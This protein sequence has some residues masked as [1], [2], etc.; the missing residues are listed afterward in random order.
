MTYRP[1]DVAP[2]DIDTLIINRGLVNIGNSIVPP[3]ANVTYAANGAG[4]LTGSYFYLVTYVTAAGETSPWVGQATPVALTAQQMRVTL[5]AAPAGVTARRLYR[6]IAG[7]S[8]TDRAAFF[9]AEVAGNGAT[10]YDDNALDGTLGAAPSW[11]S[12]NRGYLTDGIATVPT[13]RFGDQ[14]TTFGSGAGG[15]TPSYAS[16]AI[17]FRAGASMAGGTRNTLLGVYAGENLTNARENT[18]VGVHAGNATTTGTGN[19]AVGY[20]AGSTTRPLGNYNVAIGAECMGGTGVNAYGTFNVAVGFNALK[21]SGTALSRIIGVGAYAGS[22]A[23]AAS[24]VY[25]DNQDRANT[26][27]G[28]TDS[29]LYGVGNAS[30]PAQTLAANA[31]FRAG[32]KVTVAQLPAASAALGG[33]RFTVTDGSVAYASANVGATVAGGGANVVP[34][35][36]NGTAWVIG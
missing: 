7:G 10:T 36:C 32:G 25:I 5:A 3:A 24:Q 27:A 15:L 1:G 23:D 11:T 29:L 26:A 28:K 6:S 33:H 14:A 16:T 34:V 17:G 20:Q 9:L 22:Y 21:N 12:A 35:F 19:T 8:A 30:M 18:L 13:A 31:A 4:A 2:W